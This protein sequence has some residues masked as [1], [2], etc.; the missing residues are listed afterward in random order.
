LPSERRSPLTSEVL[1]EI[2]Q[3]R[4]LGPTCKHYFDHYR[5][6]LS[7]YGKPRERVALALLKAVA[8][9]PSGRIGSSAL[10]DIYR[11]ARGRRAGEADFSEL[12]ADLECEWYLALDARTNEYHFM[13]AVMRDW[14]RRW[15]GHR[16]KL[17]RVTQGG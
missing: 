7:R 8:E 10:Y 3:G 11:R 5:A 16:R 17:G 1:D 12:L 4:I 13:V 2:Y 6:R 15:Y 9:A 14:W